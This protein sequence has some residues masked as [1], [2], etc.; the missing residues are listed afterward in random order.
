[1]EQ[2]RVMC[3]LAGLCLCLMLLCAAIAGAETPAD[4]QYSIA[5]TSNASMFRVVRCILTAQGGRMEAELT[6]SGAG[7]GYLFC[8]TAE[9]AA[10]ASGEGWLPF[11]EDAEGR[12]VFTLPVA[13]LDEK[14]AVAAYSTKYD[15]WYDRELVFE[16]ATLTPW[17]A[18]KAEPEPAQE[19]E[20]PAP[21]LYSADAVTD[22]ALLTFSGCALRVTE[23][24]MTAVLTADQNRYE[25][26]YAG[27][28]RDARRD[29]AGW[30]EAGTDGERYTYRLEVPALDRDLEIA[31][32]S[33][34]KKKWY[35]RTV[36]LVS[37]S[38]SPLAE[39]ADRQ[40]IAPET[41]TFS[42]GTGKVTLT[43]PEVFLLP[44]GGAE[45]RIVFS[46]PKYPKVKAGDEWFDCVCDESTSSAV[47]PVRL[48][49]PFTVAGLTLAMSQPHEVEYTL[50]I[51]MGGED[52]AHAPLAGLRWTGSMP[53]LYAEA[54]AVE[55]YEGGYALLDVKDSARYLV[56]PEGLEPPE[57]L[58]P[59]IVVL[60]QPLQNIYMAATSAMAF[61]DRLDALDSIRFSG[62]QESGWANENARRRMAEGRIVFAGKYSE[63]DYERLLTEHCGLAVESM[64]IEHTPKVKEMLELLGIPVL[65]D[66]SSRES[67]PLGRTEWIRLYGVL[68]G[69]EAEAEAFFREQ[70]AR[71]QGLTKEPSGTKAAF[72]YIHSGGSAVVRGPQD[73]VTKMIRMAGGEDAFAGLLDPED[74]RTTVQLTMEELY[75]AALE[76]DVL[77]YNGAIDR[78]VQTVSD[79][80]TKCPLLSEAKAVREGNVFLTS[81]DF[82]QA[83]DTI[84]DMTAEMSGIFRGEETDGRYLTRLQ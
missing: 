44:D 20:R 16:S 25:R 2:M 78:D 55:Y 59:A 10:A 30:I 5:V 74:T 68:L 29:E 77:L 14:L 13:Q 17:Q 47:I 57:G 11:R 61:F 63:P 40:G 9:E 6:L 50:F 34:D 26:I 58:D 19:A 21:G 48:G 83:P 32:Y 62:T 73:Y 81:R 15:Q 75:A 65:V 18:T 52:G 53:L 37:A 82:Y 71:A 31:V 79:L 12:H 76:A 1:M 80:L 51:G 28:A 46:S 67:H 72:F 39:E 56:V 4:G 84:G 45:A 64:M 22:S 66:C 41:F 70:A 7:Y 27:K 54:F 38:L 8:G 33:A 24:G 60:R 23:E 49:E 42:G 43:C 69:R 3:S 36:R 35:D